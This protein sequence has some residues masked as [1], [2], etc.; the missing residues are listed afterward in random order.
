MIEQIK[1]LLTQKEKELKIVIQQRESLEKYK[2][3]GI[4]DHF[5]ETHNCIKKWERSLKSEIFD[6]KHMLDTAQ[7]VEN[8]LSELTK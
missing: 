2:G 6:L 8:Q 7:R 4:P 3:E 5:W 1:T